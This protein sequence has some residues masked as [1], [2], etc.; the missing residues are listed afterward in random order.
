M[1]PNLFH[2]L[3]H[4]EL[5]IIPFDD[6][7]FSFQAWATY[8]TNVKRPVEMNS[9]NKSLI[10]LKRKLSSFQIFLQIFLSG[11]IFLWRNFILI[12]RNKDGQNQ[13]YTDMLMRD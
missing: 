12:V 9:G 4:G 3:I 6:S 13:K 8:F 2:F 1:D 10:N 7:I 5:S 11:N